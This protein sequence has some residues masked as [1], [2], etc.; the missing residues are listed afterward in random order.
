[1]ATIDMGRKEGGGASVPFLRVLV[2]TPSSTMWPGPKSTAVPSG[3]FIH[4]AIWPQYRRGPKLGR[5]GCALFSGG[6]WV[7]IEHNV[8]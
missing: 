6:S 4:P 5:G 3:V 8:A 2:G 7:H 1:V